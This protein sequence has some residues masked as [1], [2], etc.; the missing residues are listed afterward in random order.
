MDPLDTAHIKLQPGEELVFKEG[1]PWKIGSPAYP[2]FASYKLANG[3]TIL[4]NFGADF[5][6]KYTRDMARAYLNAVNTYN[7]VQAG[8]LSRDYYSGYAPQPY[9][10]LDVERMEAALKRKLAEIKT[11][12]VIASTPTYYNYFKNA[13]ILKKVGFKLVGGK[14]YRNPTYPSASSLAGKFPKGASP[15]GYEHWIHLW[16]IN[17]GG[18]DSVGAFM[19]YHGYESLSVQPFPGCC[20]IRQRA[21]D[22]GKEKQA[23]PYQSAPYPWEQ[24]LTVAHVPTPQL[25]PKGWKSFARYKDFKLAVNWGHPALKTVQDCPHKFD[26]S[27]FDAHE[28]SL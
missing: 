6:T 13:C 9:Y 27:L 12:V 2:S 7:L 17:L 22:F 26:L 21:G 14:C 5:G 23:L 20:G 10:L 3:A 8:K 4:T 16:A 28:S 18:T 24:Y 25:L 15:D 19:P 11:G 1:V